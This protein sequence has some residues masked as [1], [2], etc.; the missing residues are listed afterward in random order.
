[1]LGLT[2][3]YSY[4]FWRTE[5]ESDETIISSFYLYTWKI[6]ENP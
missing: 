5:Y 1:M 6:N 2:P 4:V 3:D